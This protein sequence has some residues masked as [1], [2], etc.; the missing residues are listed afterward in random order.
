MSS[1]ACN[2]RSTHFD[3]KSSDE[4]CIDTM[5]TLAIEAGEQDKSGQA[6][7]PMG[8]APVAFPL[9]QQFLRSPPAD[10]LWPNRDRFVLSAGHAS[11]LLYSLLHLSGVKRV[12]DR[13]VTKQPA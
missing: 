8:I 3:R 4:L 9:G 5:R 1:L 7:T 13:V 12:E 6:G 10:P 2:D 11:L